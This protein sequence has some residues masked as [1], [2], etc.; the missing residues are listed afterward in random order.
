MNREGGK[1]IRSSDSYD[2]EIEALRREIQSQAIEVVGDAYDDANWKYRLHDVFGVTEPKPR[3]EERL[4]NLLTQAVKKR[5]RRLL[6][7]IGRH[8]PEQGAKEPKLSVN[9]RIAECI[10][11]CLEDG[12]GE[13]EWFLPTKKDVA[14]TLEIDIK[15]VSDFF[16]RLQIN[17]GIVFDERAVGGVWQNTAWER[18]ECWRLERKLR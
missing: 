2:E 4:I 11:G 13:G 15:R 9:H 12:L 18:F 16:H 17:T 3:A 14:E 7:W 6:Q 1:E 10:W 5:D 8:V